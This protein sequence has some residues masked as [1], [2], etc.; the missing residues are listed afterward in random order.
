[1]TMKQHF[2]ALILCASI[3][4]PA[5]AATGTMIKNDALRQSASAS[6]A[7]VGK[8]SKGAS[9][10]ILARQDGWTQIRHAGRTGWVRILSV[11]TIAGS[12]GGDALGLIEMGA[13]RSDPS[14][15]VAVAGLRGLNE[16]ELRGARF[17]AN[18]LLRLDQY[19]SSRSDAEQF[20]RS[21]GL[22]R[23][24]VAYIVLPKRKQES[25]PGSIPW[26]NGGI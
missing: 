9:V 14:R 18:E 12:A 6:A 16:E 1:M 15:V 2:L 7:S 11:K 17:N 25:T 20:A 24:E 19:L 21:A 22:R 10:Q 8:V 5:W 23:L 4:A 13:S 3:V 26:V